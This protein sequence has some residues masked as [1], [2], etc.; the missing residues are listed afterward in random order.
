MMLYGPAKIERTS[1]ITDV[2]GQE[3]LSSGSVILDKG[4][5]IV[6]NVSKDDVLPTLTVGEKVSGTYE[7]KEKETEPPKHYTDKTLIAAMISAGKDLDDEELKKVMNAGIKGIGTEATRAAI[8]E[9]LIKRGYA[10]RKKKS[11]I[12]TE[13]GIALINIL[14]LKEIKSAELTA[15]W[16]SKL[17]DI[18]EGK[19]D[20]DKFIKDIELTT[21]E[22]CNKI[23]TADNTKSIISS[24]SAESS[25]LCPV[26]GKP[27]VKRNWGWGC[28]G[29]KDGCKFSISLTIAGKKLTDRQVETLIKKRKTNVIKGFKSKAGKEFEAM[30]VLNDENKI[31]FQFPNN[32]K[33]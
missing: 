24:E 18:A 26:C 31:I 27:L 1:V 4:W 16:E 20:F 14:P 13:K 15:M 25:M 22:W 28:S 29:Y 33:K 10:E 2:I 30:L 23:N 12:A 3:F 6:D 17:N 32:S 19:G 5:M 9:A 8:I 11:V 21:K 7:A